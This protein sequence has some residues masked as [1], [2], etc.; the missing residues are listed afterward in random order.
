LVA[1]HARCTSCVRHVSKPRSASTAEW[2]LWCCCCCWRRRR[3]IRPGGP[4]LRRHDAIRS[5]HAT[6][7]NDDGWRP[8]HVHHA[9]L[10]RHADDDASGRH[11]Y[12]D[13]SRHGAP[14]RHDH[15]AADD[16]ASKRRST[17][18]DAWSTCCDAW[19]TCCDAWST[20]CNAWST[21]CNA[22]RSYTHAWSKSATCSGAWWRRWS[23]SWSWQRGCRGWLVTIS[24][25][26]YTNVGAVLAKHG[27]LR[28]VGR[29]SARSHRFTRHIE[30]RWR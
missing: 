5:L 2:C 16:D 11:R 6:T 1:S 13:D 3:S 22:W 8:G 15:D 21:C 10:W 14:S 4:V 28:V 12:A 17:C 25:A 18:C 24:S 9:S 19:S 29:P 27:V 23:W 20:C 30:R 26:W 7:W